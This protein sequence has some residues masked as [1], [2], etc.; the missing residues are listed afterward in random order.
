[1]R[2][3]IVIVRLISWNQSC[4]SE[5]KIIDDTEMTVKINNKKEDIARIEKNYNH[6]IS[7]FLA[8]KEQQLW[9]FRLL[10]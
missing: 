6:G 3:Y 10:S 5:T 8:H 4:E 2:E 9:D 1:M 7:D